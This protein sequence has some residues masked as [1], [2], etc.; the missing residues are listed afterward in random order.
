VLSEIELV[1]WRAATRT[2]AAV[3]GLQPR[4]LALT[5]DGEPEVVRGAAVTSGLFPMLG[6]PPLRRDM[7]CA[8]G[9]KIVR[10][11]RPTNAG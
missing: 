6:T 11:T 9:P 3:E 10:E 2:L 4:S 1:R 5:G 7:S 8:I